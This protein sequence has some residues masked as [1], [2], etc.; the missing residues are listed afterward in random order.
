MSDAPIPPVARA[1]GR[2]PSGLFVVTA[3]GPT[4][5]LGFVASFLVQVGLAPPTVAVAVGKGRDHL[6]AIRG[7][8]RFAVSVLDKQSSGAMGAFFKKRE[9][10]GS[11]FDDLAHAPTPAGVPYLTES[12]AWM[13]CEV[14][15]EHATDDHVVVFGTVREGALLREGEPSI[16]VRKDG[17]TY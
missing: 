12:L 14:S 16:H 17:R 5:P 13:E 6:D 8:G 2:V 11:P 1:L 3:S 7:S 10:G 9:A 4:G 15:G